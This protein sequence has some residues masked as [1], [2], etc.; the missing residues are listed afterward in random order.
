M[1]AQAEV[2]PL[3]DLEMAAWRALLRAHATL[4]RDLD[5]ELEVS[6]GL[7]LGDY[8]VLAQLSEAPDRRLRMTELA[9]RVSLTRSGLTRAVDRLARDGWVERHSCPSDA[10]GTFAVLT[11]TGADILRSAYPTHLTGVRRHLIDG[12]G[13]RDLEVLAE[14]L[15][16][17]ADRCANPPAGPDGC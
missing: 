6:H 11:S 17:I 13:R 12:L 9:T 1:R 15:G 16:R 7:S 8:E 4:T 3:D 14:A 2:R 10:R 5:L